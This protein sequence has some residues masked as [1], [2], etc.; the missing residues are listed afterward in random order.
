MTMQQAI[1]PIPVDTDV[2]QEMNH[3]FES[4]D[5]DFRANVPEGTV[6]AETE[7]DGGL[8]RFKK[9]PSLVRA[10]ARQLPERTLVY[11]T[12]TGRESRVPTGQL[13]Y[14]LGKRREDGSRVYSLTLDPNIKMATPIADTCKICF[15]LRGNRHR[16][17]YSEY[18]LLA[19]Y[20]TLHPREWA[21]MER[22]KDR[23]EKRADSNQLQLLIGALVQS[24]NPSAFAK[25]PDEVKQQMQDLAGMAAPEP[26][27]LTCPECGFEAKTAAGFSAHTR[28]HQKV[29][30]V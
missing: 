27:V 25:L 23:V 18:D 26:E 30:S 16:N 20:E 22:E 5:V 19:H 28:S 15:V 1:E 2:E 9:A 7:R 3:F 11:D 17:F 13:R 12:R 10:G 14:Q 21:S 8:F 6:L 24:L 4:V 29:E